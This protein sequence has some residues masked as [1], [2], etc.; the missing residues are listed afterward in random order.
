MKY[1]VSIFALVDF[2]HCHLTIDNGLSS[3]SGPGASAFRNTLP[4]FHPNKTDLEMI[5]DH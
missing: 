3:Q 2:P 4:N 1:S 5:Q